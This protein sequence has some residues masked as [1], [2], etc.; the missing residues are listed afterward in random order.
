[1]FD[2]GEYQTVSGDTVN[3]YSVKTS[4]EITRIDFL[5]D[6]SEAVDIR[7]PMYCF[8]KEM[9]DSIGLRLIYDLNGQAMQVRDNAIAQDKSGEVSVN[10]KLETPTYDMNTFVVVDVIS[11]NK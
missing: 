6:I 7:E 8:S 10:W 5:K 11:T 1:M 3:Y 9:H 4:Q 2:S